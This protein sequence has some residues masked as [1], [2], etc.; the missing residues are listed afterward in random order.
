MLLKEKIAFMSQFSSLDVNVLKVNENVQ[1]VLLKN[2]HM[3]L[4]AGPWDKGKA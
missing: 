1:N 2:I 3:N 4:L